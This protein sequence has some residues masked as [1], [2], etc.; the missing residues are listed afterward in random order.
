MRWAFAYS[1]SSLDDLATKALANV[2][3]GG[4]L[5]PANAGLFNVS[6]IAVQD[7]Q[8][9]ILYTCEWGTAREKWGFARMPQ[10]TQDI[11]DLDAEY[12]NEQYRFQRALRIDGDW[13]VVYDAYWAV[14]VGWS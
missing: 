8:T 10:Y 6:S 2:V 1:K 14:K 9:V 3:P 4:T 7:D 11:R 13:F 5:A 12:G